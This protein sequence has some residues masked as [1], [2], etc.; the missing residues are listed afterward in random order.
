MT[1]IATDGRTMYADVRSTNINPQHF[2]CNECG[3][4]GFSSKQDSKKISVIH[5]PLVEDRR[6]IDGKVAAMYGCAGSSMMSIFLKKIWP[7]GSDLTHIVKVFESID[8]E[9]TTIPD[10]GALIVTE[11]GT[12]YRFSISPKKKLFALKKYEAKD[13]PVSIGSGA[14]YF[15]TY[16]ETFNIG[17][18]DAFQMAIHRDPHSSTDVCHVA[19]IEYSERKEAI[20]VKHKESV[21]FP[22]KYEQTLA[23]AQRRMKLS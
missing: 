23:V 3:S 7:M 19:H 17:W 4:K 13:L 5:R 10:G 8:M 2:A 20:V 9:K 14:P 15:Q 16:L 18:F 12:V 1:T 22:R 21:R 6:F 11:D